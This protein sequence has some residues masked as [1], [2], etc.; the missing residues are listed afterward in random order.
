M[1]A[2][3]VKAFG[4]PEVLQLVEVPDPEAGPGEVLIDTSVATVLWVETV[5]R[6][7]GGPAYFDI[8]PPYT[9][10]NGVAG[11]VSAVGAGV[12]PGWIGREVVAHTGGGGGY[13]QHVAVSAE[14]V[15]AIPA[16][17]TAAEAA[18]LL[19]DGVT[20]TAIFDRLQV[21]PSDRVLVVG[22]SGGLGIVSMQLA[23]ARGARVVGTA[24]DQSKLERLRRHVQVGPIVDSEDAA[25]QQ[26]IR[27][28]L[29]EADVILDNVGGSLGEAA[30]ELL[31]PH[32]RFSAHGTPS[33]RFAALDAGRVAQRG[34][35]VITISD[36][37]L[38]IEARHGLTER[39][40]AEAAQGRV[41][42][43]IGQCWPLERAAE[44]HA[45]I[46]NRTA[47]GTTQL[48]A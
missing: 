31:A 1:Y 11:V 14:G 26:Q 16:G 25:W 10:G 39:V 20:A 7:D 38:S 30:F 18:A 43:L 3:E 47:I 2:T 23:H 15:S 21:G 17:L 36:V 24:R 45:A 48:V 40:L 35:D 5:I 29:G 6:R 27:A 33:G 12:D 44:A 34:A 37:Q 4:G 9:P 19:H 8:Q 22:A 13:A 32:G 46:E 42:P 41:R 28:G